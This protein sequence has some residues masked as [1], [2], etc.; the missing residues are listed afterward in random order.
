METKL[1]MGIIGTG[2]WGQVHA[3]IYSTHAVTELTAVC[4]LDKAKAEEISKRFGNPEVYTD[5][6]EMLETEKFDAVAIVTPDFAHAGPIISAC[7]NKKHVLVEKPLATTREDIKRIKQEVERSG[8][9]IMVD[10]HNRWN[11]PIALAKDDILEGKLGVIMSAYY[12]LNDIIS[13]PLEMLSW[14]EKSSIL[15]FLGS[16]TVDTLRFLFDDE[17]S[18]VYSVSRSQVLKNKGLDVPDLYQT[19]L[20]FEKG[21]VATIENN[22]IV[23]NSNPFIND[24]KCNVLGSKGMLDMDISHNHLFQ[25]FLET[26]YDHPDCIIKPRIYGKQTGFACESIFHFIEALSSGNTPMVTLSDGIKVS[27]VILAVMESAEKRYPVEVKY[28]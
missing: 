14:S 3:E 13:V 2:L 5:Y 19:I 28:S 7:K 11:P 27:E 12:R 17:V 1:K 21:I 4:D 18:R 9:T 10:Y 8:I 6:E 22:W 15:W 16:H 24:I 23:P 25:R 26:T 20:E